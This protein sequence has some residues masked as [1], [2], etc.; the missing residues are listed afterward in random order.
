VAKAAEV[1]AEF[2]DLGEI[3]IPPWSPRSA[4]STLDPNEGGKGLGTC[5]WR[6]R[7]VRTCVDVRPEGSQQ[8]GL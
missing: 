7:G 2:D 5:G 1:L 3:A 6:A 4:T 8:L